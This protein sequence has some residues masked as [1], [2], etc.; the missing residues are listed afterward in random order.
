IA[1]LPFENMSDDPA[2][3]YFSDGISEEILNLLASVPG[4]R[5]P[6][7]TSAFSFRDQDVP[8]REV[9]ARL[10]VDRVLDG[11]VRKM[12]NRV[13]IAVQ[14]VDAETDSP[15]WSETYERELEDIFA[16]QQEISSSIVRALPSALGLDEA[17]TSP[18]AE[19]PTESVEAYQIFL[20]GL[21]SFNNLRDLDLA[22]ELFER[23]V[24][25]D[26]G[27]AR[28]WA[29]LGWAYVQGYLYDPATSANLLARAQGA[30]QRA[31]ASDPSLPTAHGALGWLQVVQMSWAEGERS[32]VRAIES[33]GSDVLPYL[34][35]GTLLTDAGRTRDALEALLRAAD[36]DPLNGIV[37]HWLSDVYRNLGQ[38]EESL[39]HARRS[40]E[41]G[42]PGGVGIYLYH[43]RRGEDERAIE[44]LEESE[45]LAGNDPSYVRALVEAI[46]DTAKRP[47]ALEA[48]DR[49]AAGN[50]R[51]FPIQ[52]Y[53]DLSVPEVVFDELERM[54]DRGTVVFGLW[55]LWEPE[56]TYLRRHPRFADLVA[57]IGLLEYWR[58]VG[59]PDLCEPEGNG[60][61]CR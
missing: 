5:V 45:T 47:A 34:R 10:K 31:L 51:F 29:M 57:R 41:L 13:R 15:V 56:M 11:S 27:F 53:Y 24:E 39:F 50:P 14:L 49:A 42:V 26:P 25:L 44:A 48:I 38:M 46:R 6:S 1:V 9:A 32:L 17:E 19:R 18:S 20:R 2:N 54:A 61:R 52:Y 35:Y 59:W 21:Y 60:F 4:I 30:V 7:R 33:G 28:A 8:V 22:I 37:A 3:R 55:R 40:V 36:L 23:A 12:D 58:N 16:I 43:L